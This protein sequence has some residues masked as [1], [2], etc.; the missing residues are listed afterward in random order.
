MMDSE[1]EHVKFLLGF[2]ETS[3]D[4]G[5]EHGWNLTDELDAAL[6]VENRCGHVTA[7]TTFL[8]SVYDRA[9]TG[10]QPGLI[11]TYYHY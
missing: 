10:T 6:D 2:L 3:Y 8:L 7:W 9:P 1:I 5:D 4:G 11:D